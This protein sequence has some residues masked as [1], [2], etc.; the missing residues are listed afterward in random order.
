MKEHVLMV[1]SLN[2]RER[3]QQNGKKEEM[4]VFIMIVTMILEQQYGV[5]ALAR[6]AIVSGV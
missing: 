1:N 5:P 2:K 4:D 6:I 3:M